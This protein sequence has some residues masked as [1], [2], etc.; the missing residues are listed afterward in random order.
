MYTM[1]TQRHRD[2]VLI[3]LVDTS[4]EPIYTTSFPA[5]AVCP[6]NH[7][8]WIRYTL[9]EEKFLPRNP[10]METKR[11]FA[12]LLAALEIPY[13]VYNI[14]LYDL[15]LFVAFRCEEIFDWCI[16]DDT[17]YD[18]C[19]IFVQERTERGICLV[20]NS[21]VSTESKMKQ[22]SDNYYPWRARTGGEG[23]GLSFKLRYNKDYVR[24]GSKLPFSFSILIKEA[25]EWSYSPFNI[26]KPNSRNTIMVTPIFTETSANTRHIDPQKRRCMFSDETSLIYDRIEGLPFN[27]LNCL[28]QCEQKFVMK[29]CNCTLSMFF[30]GMPQYRNKECRVSDLKCIYEHKDIFNYLKGPLQDEYINDTRRGMVCDCVHNCVSLLFLVSINS[31]PLQSPNT[32]DPEID[33][34]IYFAKNTMTKYAARLQYTYMD[35]AA[36]FGGVLGLCLGASALSLLRFG[37]QPSAMSKQKIIL[38]SL[39]KFCD[40][41]FHGANHAIDSKNR[42]VLRVFWLLIVFGALVGCIFMYW[43]LTGRHQEK[44]L[45]TVVESSQKPIHNIAFPAVAVCPFNH[46]NWMR[47]KSAE[48]KFLPQNSTEETIKIFHDLLVAMERLTFTT[49]NDIELLLRNPNIPKSIQNI[50]LYDLALFMAF[51]CNEIFVWCIYDETHLDCCKVFITERT[52]RGICLVFNSLISDESKIKQLSDNY[53]PWRARTGGEGSGLSFKLRYNK[54]FV[55]PGSTLPFS[56]SILI[57]EADEWSYSPFNILKPNSRNTIMVTPIFTETSANTRHIDPQKRRYIFNYIKG[58]LQD[59]FI[60]DTSR[61]MVCNCVH[62]CVSLIF[63]LSINSQHLQSA[64]NTVPEIDLDVHFVKNTM[65]KYASRLQYTNMDLAANF[66]GILGLCLGASVL[67]VAEVVY[68]AIRTLF[69]LLIFKWNKRRRQRRVHKVKIYINNAP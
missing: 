16:Y 39:L 7:V 28:V 36:N 37:S 49:L 53:Y 21:M 62:N 61:G 6:L 48:E 26:L 43:K 17:E 20:F 66:G 59:E 1:L 32:T 51:R 40:S 24:P 18:C 45:V 56:F 22:L 13:S 41:G 46:I 64:N 35:L 57:K 52:E 54:A 2:Q 60:N 30:P 50:V 12:E 47:H 4:R 29:Y 67:S 3:T 58:P 10:S 42:L 33:V 8:N 38:Q 31:Q 5:V 25:D 69:A 9:A 14:I 11:I 23:S 65:T 68:A 19:K 15:L 63:L 27:R 55:R 34:D 44:I